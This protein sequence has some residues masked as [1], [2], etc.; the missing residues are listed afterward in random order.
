[1]TRG[2]TY[3]NARTSRTTSSPTSSQRFEGTRLGRQEL[4]A[5]SSK[6][7][8]ARSGSSL[9]DATRVDEAP[10]LARIAVAVDPSATNTESSAETGIIAAGVDTRGHGYVLRDASGSTALASGASAVLLHDA[11]SADAIV[12]ETNQGGDMAV[13]VITTAAEKLHRAKR[14]TPHITVVRVHASRGKRACAGPRRALRAGPGA[15]RA[16]PRKLEDQLTTWDASDGTPLAGSP[17]R[18]RVGPHVAP[19]AQGPP[20]PSVPREA[21][22]SVPRRDV[23]RPADD[24]DEDDD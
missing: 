15:S 22:G 6:T 5:E 24:P 9:L 11:L 4:L 2:S 20:R 10:E 16:V 13:H 21:L 7:R 8:P 14:A 19:A 3:E 1:M 17:R 12:V 18:A 23:A